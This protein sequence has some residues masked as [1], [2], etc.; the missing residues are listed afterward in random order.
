MFGH[1]FMSRLNRIPANQ[2]SVYAATGALTDELIRHH[3]VMKIAAA[4]GPIRSP[5]NPN[6]AS[7]PSVVIS[8][9]KSGMFVSRPIRIGRDVPPVSSSTWT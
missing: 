8:T 4:T 9:T 6:A 7:P 3:T 1:L 5:L 2:L